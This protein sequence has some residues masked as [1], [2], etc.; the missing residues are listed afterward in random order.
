MKRFYC[1]PLYLIGFLSVILTIFCLNTNAQTT[2]GNISGKVKDS[3]GKPLA[4]VQIMAV[5][6]STGTVRGTYTNDEGEYRIA[7]VTPGL[8]NVTAER[9]GYARTVRNN[10]RVLIGVTSEA[11]FTLSSKNIVAKEVVVEATPPLV[12]TKTSAVAVEVR[13][14][15]IQSLPLNS[16]NF[17]ELATI[18]PGAKTS[19]G[20]RGPITTGALNSRFINAYI[21]GVG[22]KNYDLGGVLGTSFGET[23]NIVPEDAIQEF[24]VIT[25]M[26]K[27]E[28]SG[29][30]NG[31]INAITKSGGNQFKGTAFG[32]F[33]SAGFKF[34][35][36]V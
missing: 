18:A 21:D 26:Y 27:A 4:E 35:R 7:L 36:S 19:T 20:G 24:Q 12:D 2:T 25:S 16:R 29:A 32:M 34:K 5:N 31:V 33:R 14:E 10:M 9:I 13:P 15:Q 3:H 22:F 1:T 8:Y 17:L 23:T 6:K 30:S 28:Y 11:D